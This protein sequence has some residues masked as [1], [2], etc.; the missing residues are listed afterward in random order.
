MKKR[1][2]G[3]KLSRE[4]DTRRAL[5]RTLIKAL[6]EHG[7][8][9]TT[10]AKAKS[11]QPDVD[12][13]VVLSKEGS[14]SSLRRVYAYLGNDTKTA[15]DLLKV[16]APAFKDRSSGFTRIVKIGRRKGDASLMVSLEWVDKVIREEEKKKEVKEGKKKTVSKKTSKTKEVK[17][18]PK[19]TTKKTEKKATKKK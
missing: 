11:I 17:K 3:R 14:V 2:F 19:V 10:L 7:K 8:I 5:F 1:V 4:R 13:L 15:R 6:V 16:V 18:K 12:R 9:K